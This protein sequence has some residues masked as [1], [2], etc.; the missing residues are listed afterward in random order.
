MDAALTSRD[1][2]ASFNEAVSLLTTAFG[3]TP[4]QI[5]ELD[6]LTP[7][8]ADLSGSLLGGLSG[9]QLLLDF[10]AA[11]YG[12]HIDATPGLNDEFTD[13][14]S[15]QLQAQTGAA[16]DGRIDLLTVLLH[17]MSHALGSEHEDASEHSLLSEE[18]GTGERRLPESDAS[19]D[20]VD[21]QFTPDSGILD[22]L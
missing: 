18:L 17:E 6:G 21:L 9:D 4:E 11:G 19:V 13:P 10:N 12:W 8:I 15:G 7:V 16:A 5:A 20:D 14:G 3:L 2:S 22:V 1:V